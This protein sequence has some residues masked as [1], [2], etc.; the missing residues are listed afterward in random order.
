MAHT[1]N[2]CSWEDHDLEASLDLHSKS[3]SPKNTYK[4]EGNI[5]ADLR[6]YLCTIVDNYPQGRQKTHGRVP[7][8]TSS[9]SNR[10]AATFS[11]RALREKPRKL[12]L[13]PTQ[14]APFSWQYLYLTSPQNVLEA[15]SCC[16]EKTFFL[17]PSMKS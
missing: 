10:Q 6:F 15:G 2:L 4:R 8:N 16:L 7:G 9:R 17:C 3:L 14:Q 12:V 11:P 13:S 1:G 5:T